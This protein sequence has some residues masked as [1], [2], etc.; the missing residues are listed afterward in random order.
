MAWVGARL[1]V[2]GGGMDGMDGGM[3]GGSVESHALGGAPTWRWQSNGRSV[4]RTETGEAIP[5]ANWD[6]ELA[7]PKEM[8]GGCVAIDALS[9]STPDRYGKW[10]SEDCQKRVLPFLVCQEVAPPPAPPPAP[11]ESPPSQETPGM[12]EAA[13]G[14]TVAGAVI[15]V[16]LVACLRQKVLRWRQ[17][18]ADDSL[19]DPA[20]PTNTNRRQ[21]PSQS[22]HP[23]D[24]ARRRWRK[25]LGLAAPSACSSCTASSGLRAPP[26][27]SPRRN[28]SPSVSPAASPRRAEPW[29]GLVQRGYQPNR[30]DH[31]ASAVTHIQSHVRRKAVTT[32][33]SVTHRA[34]VSIQSAMRGHAARM[35]AAQQ[36]SNYGDLLTAMISPR[37]LRATR[38]SQHATSRLANRTLKHAH[39]R[40]RRN[41]VEDSNSPRQGPPTSAIQLAVQSCQA[42]ISG[43]MRENASKPESAEKP[44]PG[45]F[46]GFSFNHFL[47]AAEAYEASFDSPPLQP[48][49]SPPPPP[50]RSTHEG[51]TPAN[52]GRTCS[53]AAL[54]V[55]R[56]SGLARE[57]SF[58]EPSFSCFAPHEA[59]SGHAARAAPP[60]RPTSE[61]TRA[62][63]PVTYSSKTASR[64]V[65]LLKREPSFSFFAPPA[66]PLDAPPPRLPPPTLVDC[67]LGLKGTSQ[68]DRP[69]P[70]LIREPPS[71]SCVFAP[72]E[73]ASLD[74]TKRKEQTPSDSHRAH[75]AEPLLPP[76]RSHRQAIQARQTATPSQSSTGASPRN[77]GPWCSPV[78][79]PRDG[80]ICSP[81]ATPREAYSCSPAVTPRGSC[82]PA[83]TPRELVCSPAATPREA[84]SCSPAVTPRGSSSPAVTPR[85]LICSPATTPREAYSCSPAVTPRHLQS[86]TMPSSHSLTISPRESSPRA[87]HRDSLGR[88]TG[89]EEAVDDHVAHSAARRTSYEA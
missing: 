48:K 20:T 25:A 14:A 34:I 46:C 29:G 23:A 12:D 61:P 59:S 52:C 78:P 5:Y 30:L 2:G 44:A 51:R 32:R 37:R 16:V 1:D 56:P 87:P 27:N 72:R 9:R 65:G 89:L 75:A 69:A 70:E 58:S 43:S 38:S 55:T 19:A 63:C 64:P 45:P 60:A 74:A 18:K 66:A 8:V 3:G 35:V 15:A 22:R 41:S 28:G 42:R 83:V 47:S 82:S 40:S 36:R 39:A 50:A 77:A 6:T 17:R 68:T 86:A 73:C 53:R 54:P 79:T 80:P 62:S 71:A 31:R 49:P 4:P 7:E 21:T 11:P 84:Y 10:Y 88:V 26:T 57:P 24:V 67:Q 85:G 81:A 33:T 76:P 13:I